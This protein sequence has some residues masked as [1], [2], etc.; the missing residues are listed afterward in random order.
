LFSSPFFFYQA[1]QSI[2][3]IIGEGALTGPTCRGRVRCKNA[4]GET[5]NVIVGSNSGNP[6]PLDIAFEEEH[7]AHYESDLEF[8]DLHQKVQNNEGD[9]EDEKTG[10]HD[11][12]QHVSFI[13]SFFPVQAG[14]HV[15]VYHI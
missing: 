8:L 11:L 5:Q 7:V 2:N 9:E 1:N 3:Q 10:S 12:S 14:G 15:I 13:A 6:N 4:L